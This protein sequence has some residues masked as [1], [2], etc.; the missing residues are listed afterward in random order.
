ML[1]GGWEEVHMLWGGW[2]EVHMLWGGW[3]E[4]HMLWGGWEE[5]HMYSCYA[6]QRGGVTCYSINARVTKM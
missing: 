2:E 1:W 5:V 6:T 4:V 3:E